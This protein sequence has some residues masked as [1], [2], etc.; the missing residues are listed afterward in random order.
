MGQKLF[1]EFE[2]VASRGE[3]FKKCPISTSDR[4]I[5]LAGFLSVCRWVEVTFLWRPNLP[6]EGDNH[7]L[8]LVVAGGA[9]ALITHNLKDFK[10]ELRF[11]ATRIL[12]P[13]QF[14]KGMR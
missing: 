13:A 6:D 7:V 3:L 12:S 2:D 5:L 11:P 1:L 14:L 8:E 10:G 4:E 9:T